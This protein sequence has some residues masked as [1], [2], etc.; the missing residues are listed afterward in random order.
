MTDTLN[1]PAAPRLPIQYKGRKDLLGQARVRLELVGDMLGIA[2]GVRD[3]LFAPHRVVQTASPVRMDDGEVQVFPGY[4]VEHSNVLGPYYGG[5]RFHHEADLDTITALA[6]LTTWQAALMG[7]P[8]GGAKGGVT[9]DPKDL[10]ERELEILTRKLVQARVV[11]ASR[12][13]RLA[14]L[15]RRGFSAR[16]R[17]PAA[18]SCP[19]HRLAAPA[20][21]ACCARSACQ[22]REARHRPRCGPLPACLPA[23]PRRRCD[24]SWAPMRTSQ[25]PT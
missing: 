22:Q 11:P 3:R 7:V 21:C 25:H 5:I 19:G 20:C 14:S 13:A 24:P 8:F 17:P 16:R 1:V 15:S 9:V 18:G 4:R 2:P 10:S 6:I 12:P 23:R